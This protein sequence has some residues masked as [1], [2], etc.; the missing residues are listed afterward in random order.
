MLY[1]PLTFP[2]CPCLLSPTSAH[3]SS[4]EDPRCPSPL[5]GL[6]DSQG[7]DDAP[8]RHTHGSRAEDGAASAPENG[9]GKD[10]F[11]R[12]DVAKRH[13]SGEQG[14]DGEH[15]GACYM[16]CRSESLA[17]MLQAQESDIFVWPSNA[18][19]KVWREWDVEGVGG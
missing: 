3:L 15:A 14:G 10:G 18:R 11:Q 16:R 1:Q 17:N 13:R 7:G 8:V 12:R 6:Q 4:K 19:Y 9:A 5:R 2:S